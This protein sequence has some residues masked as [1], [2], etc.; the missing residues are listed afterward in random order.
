MPASGYT[1]NKAVF[2]TRPVDVGLPENRRQAHKLWY[3]SSLLDS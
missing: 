1:N 3:A 2:L